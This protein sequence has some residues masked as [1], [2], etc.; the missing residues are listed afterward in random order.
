MSLN[1]KF[2]KIK[3]NKKNKDYLGNKSWL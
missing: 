3:K 1:L 2:S